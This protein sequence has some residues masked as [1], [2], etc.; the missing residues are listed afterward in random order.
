MNLTRLYFVI[1]KLIF[2]KLFFLQK[3]TLMKIRSLIV[4]FG[5]LWGCCKDQTPI[6]IPPEVDPMVGNWLTVSVDSGMLPVYP[7][8]EFVFFERLDL[9]GSWSFRDDNSGTISGSID[10]LLF[11]LSDFTWVKN[12]SIQK[13]HFILNNELTYGL[14]QKLDADSLCFLFKD[15]PEYQTYTGSYVYYIIKMSRLD[16]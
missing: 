15:W 3:F 14:I 11:S 5:I 16:N 2:Q 6:I 4:L 8:P 9:E 7:N 13:L 1:F 10:R 12:D